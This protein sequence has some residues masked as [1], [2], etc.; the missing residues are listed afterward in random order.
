MGTFYYQDKQEYSVS[1]GVVG[2]GWLDVHAYADERIGRVEVKAAVEV[3][4]VGTYKTPFKI[5]VPAGTYTLN[6]SY[7]DQTDS[8]TATVEADKTTRVEF[9]FVAPVVSIPWIMILLPV[10]MGVA[11]QTPSYLK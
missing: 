9:E 8:K 4:G 7:H 11:L 1:A 2:E 10:A 3:V 6:A 5:K